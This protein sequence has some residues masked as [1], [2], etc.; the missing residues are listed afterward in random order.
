MDSRFWCSHA[1]TP[2]LTVKSAQQDDK[3]KKPLNHSIEVHSTTT[4]VKN[5][6]NELVEVVKVL[7]ND[8]EREKMMFSPTIIELLYRAKVFIT[9]NDLRDVNLKPLSGVQSDSVVGRFCA[10]DVAIGDYQ[11]SDG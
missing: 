6:E 7:N 3:K 8:D 11:K 1:A 5:G 9:E 4:S 2:R 10:Y